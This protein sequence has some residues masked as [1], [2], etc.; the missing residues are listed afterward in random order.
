VFAL[1]LWATA[2]VY[3]VTF[4]YRYGYANPADGE[5]T[6][7][8]GVPF[9]AFWGIAVP[10]TVCTVLSVAFALFWMRDDPLGEEAA[11]PTLAASESAS[12]GDGHA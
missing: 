3:S 2:L 5:L 4:C 1:S 6:F 7:V 9:W 8:F 12:A 11:D 10:W